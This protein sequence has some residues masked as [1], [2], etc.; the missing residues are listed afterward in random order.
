[1]TTRIGR[2]RGGNR[3][4]EIRRSVQRARLGQVQPAQAPQVL[5]ICNLCGQPIF[6]SFKSPHPY[7]Y[8]VDHTIPTAKGGPDV[9]ANRAP[10]HRIC[11]SRKRD[12][13]PPPRVIEAVR[14]R[15]ATERQAVQRLA[16]A[17]RAAQ[18]VAPPSPPPTLARAFR[19]IPR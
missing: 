10:A 2:G 15:L 12:T 16:A 8:S 18:R 7:S 9:P 3:R 5:A 1:M 17:A 14:A 11:N 4:A 6:A 13:M 19:S